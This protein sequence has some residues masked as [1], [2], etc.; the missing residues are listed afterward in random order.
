MQGWGD[1]TGRRRK[2]G[3]TG[4]VTKGIMYNY[5]WPVNR[6]RQ[7]SGT[8]GWTQAVNE[9][10]VCGQGRLCHGEAGYEKENGRLL[11]RK[12]MYSTKLVPGMEFNPQKEST[13]LKLYIFII[14]WP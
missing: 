11:A 12:T 1:N 9:P 3:P 10:F 4:R 5:G 7:D 13:N 8:W 14:S 2:P 6:E